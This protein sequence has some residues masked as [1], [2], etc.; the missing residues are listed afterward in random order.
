MY[1]KFLSKLFKI[2]K[3]FCQRLHTFW[4]ICMISAHPYCKAKETYSATGLT[5]AATDRLKML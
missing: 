3:K 1:G 4:S 5:E 2:N